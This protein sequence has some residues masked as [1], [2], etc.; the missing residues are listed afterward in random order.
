MCVEKL[1]DCNHGELVRLLEEYE[2][3][4]RDFVVIAGGGVS[5]DARDTALAM[6]VHNTKAALERR[7]EKD[8]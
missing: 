5:A 8:D 7:R 3:L 4:L 2:E 1:D 6:L